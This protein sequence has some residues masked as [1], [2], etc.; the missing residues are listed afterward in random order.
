MP[1]TTIDRRLDLPPQ[2]RYAPATEIEAWIDRQAAF[3]AVADA[4]I[5]AVRL[6][7]PKVK[8][9]PRFYHREGSVPA[10]LRIGAVWF[11]PDTVGFRVDLFG[12]G[13][14]IKAFTRNRTVMIDCNL[15]SP[16]AL[17]GDLWSALQIAEVTLT[18][19][20]PLIRDGH[21]HSWRIHRLGCTLHVTA[22]GRA[23]CSCPEAAQVHAAS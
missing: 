12:A 6:G 11:T 14:R 23:S 15:L 19:E 16:A 13:T 2:G 18:D 10:H 5:P 9:G 1:T 22:P 7:E 4:A 8:V 3:L 17:A 21:G 20:L